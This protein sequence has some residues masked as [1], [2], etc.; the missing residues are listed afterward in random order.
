MMKNIFNLKKK[1]LLCFHS[2]TTWKPVLR[3]RCLCP[4]GT[5]TLNTSHNVLPQGFTLTVNVNFVNQLVDSPVNW[6]CDTLDSWCLIGMLEV[7][8]DSVSSEPAPWSILTLF[9]GSELILQPF[10]LHSTRQPRHS[11]FSWDPHPDGM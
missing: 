9:P 11:S 6:W 10:S 3:F 5:Q 1:C 7:S 2:N 4:Q 8:V